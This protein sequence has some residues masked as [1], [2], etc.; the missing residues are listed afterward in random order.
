[1][2]Q[3]IRIGLLRLADSAPV[4]VARNAGLFARHGIDA[5]IVV[6]PSWANIADGLA[7]NGLD[8]ALVFPPLA[9]MTA[10]GQRG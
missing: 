8:A 7:W 9:I 4:L 2:T 5:E 1:M 3:T 6:A 10:L